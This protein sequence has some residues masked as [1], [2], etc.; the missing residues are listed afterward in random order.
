[1][2]GSPKTWIKTL[3]AVAAMAAALVLAPR[4]AA[5][6]GKYFYLDRLQLGGEPQDGITVWRP[7]FG[8]ETTFYGTV[9]AAYDLNALRAGTV[10]DNQRVSSSI[11]NPVSNQFFG[12]FTGGVQ[13]LGRGSLSVSIPV[14]FV[15]TENEPPGSA[16]IGNGFGTAPAAYDVRLDARFQ[17]FEDNQR[18]FRVGLFG[19]IF[20]GTGKE[21][22]FASDGQIT[23]SVLGSVD[24]DVGP[25][26]LSFMAGP[27]F[28]PQRAIGGR[29]GDLY[30]GNE[31]RYAGGAYVPL[32]GNEV[33]L[34]LELWGSLGLS[35]DPNGEGTFMNVRN[36]TLEWMAQGRFALGRHAY[37]QAGA[38]TRLT[39]G[40]GAADVRAVAMLGGFFTPGA[41]GEKQSGKKRKG[42]IVIAGPSDRDGDGYPDDIDKCP[43][44]PED[45]AQP[46]PYDGCPAQDRDGDGIDDAADD[47]PDEPE[48]MDGIQ[49]EDGCPETDADRDNINDPEDAC[50]LEPGLR[51]DDPKVN[52]CPTST[53]FD[54]TTGE[55]ILLRPVQFQTGKARILPGSFQILDEVVAVVNSHRGSRLAIHGHTD[56]R[57]GRAMNVRLSKARAGAVVKYLTDHG[58]DSSRLES[59]GFGPDRPVDTNS[60]AA[61]RAHNRRVE[62]K[63]ISE[64]EVY[65]DAE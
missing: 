62:F 2:T 24:A 54:E 53:R 37:F 33:R 25:L 18:K 51:S 43:D 40:Y 6:Q 27:H 41:G 23:G 35:S 8:K 45:G 61:G 59:E 47:C 31:L 3:A 34:G 55:I 49:D 7:V 36:S 29:N 52:G 19:S 20:T 22:A 5:A 50:P 42:P 46:S 32:R 56:S 28:K 63:L 4:D 11:D 30:T 58:I 13:L 16:R 1:M 48:D 17:V 65:I 26:I 64:E 10:T 14:A 57:G 12:Y 44:I 38:G 60:T 39:A 21:D 9:A 15:Q